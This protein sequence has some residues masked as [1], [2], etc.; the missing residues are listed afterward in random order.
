MYFKNNFHVGD[1]CFPCL[2][3]VHLF[4]EGRGWR[5]P[6][7]VHAPFVFYILVICFNDIDCID[8]YLFKKKKKKKKLGKKMLPSTLDMVPSPSTWNP[9]PSTLD[10]K[11]DS[12]GVECDVC[13]S[14][15]GL[16]RWQ[17]LF[18]VIVESAIPRRSIIVP[19][20]RNATQASA[21]MTFPI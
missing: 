19:P 14:R 1:A 11:I 4:V 18:L 12:L 20:S 13:L 5:V 9:R 21:K 17:N 2:G 15:A 6:C 16:L 10:K 7:R 3:R 8:Y